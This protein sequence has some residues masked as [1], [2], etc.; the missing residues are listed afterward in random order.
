MQLKTRN[1]RQVLLLA[2]VTL[3]ES[4]IVGVTC[5][6]DKQ[7]NIL[8]LLADDMGYSGVGPY[9]SEIA[10]PDISGTWKLDNIEKVK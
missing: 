5:S 10:T 4:L 2:A 1:G 9:G 6:A 3:A 8:I 7:P